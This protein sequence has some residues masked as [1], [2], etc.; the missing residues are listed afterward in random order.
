MLDTAQREPV[1]DEIIHIDFLRVD[2]TKPLE[3]DIAV[4]GT[5][6]P[7]GQQEGGV[8]DQIV[9]SVRVRCLPDE[10]PSN[11]VVDVTELK[12]NDAI[13]VGELEVAEGVE[14][15]SPHSEILF[16]VVQPR[17]IEEEAVAEDEEGVEEGEE[18]AE[19]EEAAEGEEKAEEK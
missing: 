7:V 13:H 4:H 3:V 8:L 15:L 11:F 18:G 2:M 16:H 1:T 6:V 5:G 10:I 19:G 9:R 12:M 14:I 17:K